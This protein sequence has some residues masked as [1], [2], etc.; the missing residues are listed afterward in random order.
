[1]AGAVLERELT[2]A[3]RARVRFDVA[4]RADDAEIRRL[5]RENPMQ[6]RI[7]VSLERE[8]DYFADANLPWEIKQTVVARTRGRVVGVGSCT[9]RRTFVDGSAVRAGYLGGLRLDTAYAGRFD[10]L[11]RGYELFHEL[12]RSA[13]ADVYFTSI[14]AHNERARNFL[15]RGIR[16]MPR[17]EFTGEFVTLLISTRLPTGSK[18][19]SWRKAKIEQLPSE[20]A[21][22]DKLVSFINEYNAA[23]QFAPCWEVDELKAVRGLSLQSSDFCVISDKGGITA[24]GALWDQRNFKQ[25]VIRGYAPSMA[26]AR[27]VLNGLARI[28]GQPHLPR[29]GETLPNAF[30]SH[31]AVLPGN[32]DSLIHVL[33]EL[34]REASSR[35]IELLTLGFAA[36]DPRLSTVRGQFRCRE[37]RS[38]LYVVSWPGIGAT[39]HDLD[40]RFPAPEAA[41]L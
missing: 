41:L 39:I 12:Q 40:D 37:Y 5:L 21:A 17:Y 28:T 20:S 3:P 1:M 6:G 14:A 18:S 10:I 33:A 7:S 31:L 26:I 13:P 19:P 2:A 27:P 4:D 25:T 16:G 24:T 11:R 23:Y 38:R 15:E 29:V 36:N 30:A 8:P 35:G 9:T 34:C 22:T 32:S